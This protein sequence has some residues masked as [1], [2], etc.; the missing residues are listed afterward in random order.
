MCAL[1]VLGAGG[2]LGRALLAEDD[3]S[4][5][6]KALDRTVPSGP[7]PGPRRI[8][9]FDRDLL[10][11]RALEGVLDPGDVVVNL[12][13]LAG[14]SE[15]EN[16]RLTEH[17]VE[18]C[19]GRG[20]AR[21]VHCSTA[22]VAGGTK[23]SLIDEFTPCEPQTS[24]EGTKLALEGIALG[25]LSGGVDVGILRPTA[26]LG[27]G[28]SNLLK[29]ARSLSAGR[30][31]SNYLRASLYGRRPMHLVPVRNVAAALLHLAFLPAPLEGE[32]YIVSSDDDP[33]N[34]F[35]SVEEILADALGLES[36]RF[37]L[38]PLPGVF[39]SLALRAL[40]RSHTG[41]RRSY[42][43]RKLLGT[44]FVPPETVAGAVRRF[45]AW[46]REEAGGA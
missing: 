6:V 10:D 4:G 18:G 23:Q 20:V 39:L 16:L 13:F 11:P 14:G 29:L 17:V 7:E 2:F 38:L 43:S 15:A 37:P 32:V 34:D 31:L 42:S 27:P 28:G 46:F 35:L 44:G 40:G 12:A 8:T 3:V 25:A 26:I 30:S 5:P 36:R 9:W 24:Y 21:L 19:A 45:G 1:V 41:L 33:D 22:V